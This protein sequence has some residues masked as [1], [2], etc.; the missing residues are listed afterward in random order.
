MDWH[1]VISVQQQ[2]P[3]NDFSHFS[4]SNVRL[5]FWEFFSK[6]G[7]T[8]VSHRVEMITRWPGRERWPKWPI[9]PVTQW[10][11]SMS[12]TH[13]HTHTHRRTSPRHRPWQSSHV[14]ITS[15]PSAA[16]IWNSSSTVN[17]F[18][19]QYDTIQTIG[20]HQK[21]SSAQSNT[22]MHCCKCVA[23]CK[24][25]I[26]YD[27]RCYFNVRS[28]ADMSRVNLP[29]GIISLQRGRFCTRSLAS[30]IPRSSK[31]RSSWMFFITF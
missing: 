2:T 11:S 6:T 1:P 13:T 3:D 24:D 12:D 7:K 28:K 26:R 19:R 10:P 4:I 15:S 25:I 8:Q 29:H 22:S 20:Y 9:D 31:D 14:N 27:T 16:A 17:I 21:H 30:C 5:A 23:L 18:K